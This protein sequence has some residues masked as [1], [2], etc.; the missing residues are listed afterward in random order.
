MSLKTMLSL[1]NLQE[2]TLLWNPQATPVSD[3]SQWLLLAFNSLVTIY[4]F[5][6]WVVVIQKYSLVPLG[7]CTGRS[8][9]VQWALLNIS[10]IFTRSSSHK[11]LV[12][13]VLIF[14]SILL[15]PKIPKKKCV[16]NFRRE[17]PTASCQS[18]MPE[19][20]TT[21]IEIHF[22]RPWRPT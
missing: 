6:G 7:S 18:H 16:W 22:E 20:T 17:Q 8:K 2:N 9:T 5:T 13:K 1:L 14:W 10:K 11:L 3:T 15:Y 21:H 4:L 12:W 19:L